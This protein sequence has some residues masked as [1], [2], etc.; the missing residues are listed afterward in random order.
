M[1]KKLDIEMKSR[2]A[3][4]PFKVDPMEK[5]LGKERNP[6]TTPRRTEPLE[7]RRELYRSLGVDL[8]QI[9]GINPLPPQVLLTEAGPNLDR[10]PTAAAFCSWLP[11]CP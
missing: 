11:Q 7:L 4:L 5:P 6:R 1:I 9:P 10:F 2:M 8:T 3:R